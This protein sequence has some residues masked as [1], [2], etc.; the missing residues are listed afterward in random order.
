MSNE[1]KSETLGEALPREI[2]RVRDKVL[3][4]YIAAGAPGAIAA[5]MMRADMDAATRALSEGDIIAMLR[6]YESLKG[7]S[8]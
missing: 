4:A 8:T 2:A 3:P 6:C 1:P 7:Y 5:A